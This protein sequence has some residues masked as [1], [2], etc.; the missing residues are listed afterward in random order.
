[1]IKK[2]AGHSS[3]TAVHSVLSGACHTGLYLALSRGQSS[4]RQQPPFAIK[5]RLSLGFMA[6]LQQALTSP[7]GA[8]KT[9]RKTECE[10]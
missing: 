3:D 6:D 10:Q 8:H 9:L 4:A 7:K 2:E 5:K 1:M